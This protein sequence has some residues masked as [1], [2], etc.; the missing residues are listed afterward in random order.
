MW[1]IGADPEVFL[2]RSNGTIVSAVGLLGGTKGKP[3]PMTGLSDGFGMQEDNVMAEFNIPPA[4]TNTEFG[5]NIETAIGWLHNFVRTKRLYIASKQYHGF[6][7]KDL[8]NEQ[9]KTFGCSPDFDAYNR[10]LPCP[11]LNRESLMQP[12]GTELRFCGGHVH[13]GTDYKIP[14]DVLAHFCDLFIALPLVSFDTQGPRR[15]R[16]GSPGRYRITPYGIEYRTLSN[17]W[18]YSTEYPSIVAGCVV[19]MG[20]FLDTFPNDARAVYGGL[21]WGEIGEAIRTEDH[22]M[23]AHLQES[24]THEFPVL[25]RYF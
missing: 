7:A 18:V 12:D 23:A 2:K 4:R 1:T 25:G 15:S 6:A 19:R 5:H 9:A 3:V 21:Q 17:K 20:G 14:P 8:D 11:S 13:I 16:Y 24:I 22:P 10:G